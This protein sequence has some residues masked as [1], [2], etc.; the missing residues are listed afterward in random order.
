MNKKNINRELKFEIRE[1][2]EYYWK[3]TA[4]CDQEQENKI[5]GQL[6][7][8]LKINLLIESNKI[9][10]KDSSVFHSNFSENVIVNTVPLIKQ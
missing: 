9:V 7:D 6:S 3:E 10:L 5:I 2:L 4:E 1:Y 8:A